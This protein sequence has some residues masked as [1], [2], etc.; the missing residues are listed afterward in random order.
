MRRPWQSFEQGKIAVL[1]KKDPFGYQCA[2]WIGEG[3]NGGVK[4]RRW[5]GRGP[6]RESTRLDQDRPVGRGRGGREWALGLGLRGK[7]R[8]GGTGTEVV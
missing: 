4:H 6:G 7:A 5:A 8:G 3:K 1:H 2:G